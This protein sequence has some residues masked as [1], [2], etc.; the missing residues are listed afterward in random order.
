MGKK[1]VAR[2]HHGKKKTCWECNKWKFPKNWEVLEINSPGE[3][4]RIDKSRTKS[5][6]QLYSQVHT[7]APNSGLCKSDYIQEGGNCCMQRPQDCICLWKEQT[8]WRTSPKKLCRNHQGTS[9]TLC[10]WVKGWGWL[11][12]CCSNWEL[13]DKWPCEWIVRVNV[14][15]AAICH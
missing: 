7:W 14:L 5:W 15:C 2:K 6:L 13:C 4:T 3:R 11:Q 1:N 9:I 10:F 8:L 12:R